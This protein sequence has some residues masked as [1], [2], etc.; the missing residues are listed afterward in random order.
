M[1]CGL[2]VVGVDGQADDAGVTRP[3]MWLSWMVRWGK[4]DVPAS[5]VGADWIGIVG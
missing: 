1:G 5:V 4:G 2:I 3:P